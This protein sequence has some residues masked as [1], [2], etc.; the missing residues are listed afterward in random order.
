VDLRLVGVDLAIHTERKS[1]PDEQPGRR[2][3]FLGKSSGGINQNIFYNAL[4]YLI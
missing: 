2:S 1:T 3:R 4:P